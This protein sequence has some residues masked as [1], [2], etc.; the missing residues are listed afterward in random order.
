ME[1]KELARIISTK[2]YREK[3]LSLNYI[4]MK[5]LINA[6]NEMDINEETFK[7]VRILIRY[8]RFPILILFRK[9]YDRLVR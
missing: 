3:E 7:I 8:F 5:Q 6:A 1:Y 4:K 2:R 9:F